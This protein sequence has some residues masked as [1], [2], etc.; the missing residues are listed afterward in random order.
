MSD[1]RGAK[2]ANI[3]D[4]ARLAGVSHQT[5]SRVLND[6][7][8]VRPATRA[9][10]EQAMAQ[11]RYSPSPAA[12]ALVTKRTR[13]IGL[14]TPGTADFGP[15]SVAMHFNVAARVE[16]YSVDSVTAADTDAAS[17]RSVVEGLLRQRVDAIVI[18][19]NDLGVLEVVRGLDLGVPMVAAAATQRRNRQLV[20]IDQYRGAR[21][22]VRHLAE[23]GHRRIL[24]IAGP[25][26]NPDAV[27]RIRGWRDELGAHQLAVVEP[28]HGDWTAASGAEIGRGLDL[29]PGDAVFAGND[30]M[31]IGLLSALRGRGLRVPDDVAVVGFDDVPEAAYLSPPLTT[32]RQD[33]RALGELM[34]QKVLL[35][36]EEPDAL[37]E[38]TPLPTHLIVRES[39]VAVRP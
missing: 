21:S 17:I 26:R 37:T 20:S 3:F 24:H 35:A 39:S 23:R 34:M 11:L 30:H 38:D 13:T 4:V 6:L 32:V 27:E 14:I 22:A 8:N 25:A 10:V 12:R 7:P 5:V 1:E 29:E 9:R 36:V 2:S 31:A 15:T 18:V 33:F 28:I 16:R 19:V